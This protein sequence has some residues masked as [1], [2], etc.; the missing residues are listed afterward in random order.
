MSITNRFSVLLCGAALILS[1]L[2]C[3]KS[4]DQ[5]S[6]PAEKQAQ[7]AAESRPPANPLRN[8]YFGDLHLHSGYSMDAFAMGTRTTP[9]DAYRYAMGDTVN[10]FGSHKSASR[11]RLSCSY[12]SR[13][14]PGRRPETINPNGAFAKTDWYTNMTSKDPSVAATAFHKVVGTFVSNEPLP[15]LSDPKAPAFHMV[16][17]SGDA[18]KYNK[19]GKFTSFIA[20]EWTSAPKFQNLHRCV[21]FANKG[22]EIPFSA[23]DSLDPEALWSYLEGQRKPGSM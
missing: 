21:I 14:V 16:G 3:S 13:R 8:A 6:T 19:P 7:T 1:L 2:G 17:L 18:E 5:T 12:R 23:F 10:Y 11:P 15:E 9:D 22:P 4:T 20:F